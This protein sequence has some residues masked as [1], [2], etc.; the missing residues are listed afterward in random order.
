MSEEVK[1]KYIKGMP[2]GGIADNGDVVL[3][4]LVYKDGSA[5][6]FAFDSE[7]GQMLLGNLRGY[8]EEAAKTRASGTSKVAEG[9]APYRVTN[10]L[11]AGPSVDGT[12]V[13][14]EFATASGFPLALAMTNDQAKQTV[15]L[16]QRSIQAAQ[17]SKDSLN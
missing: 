2:W 15:E 3:F 7:V 17:K 10:I 4:Q 16:L 5:E 9:T 14:V 1:A 11:R 8:A 13:S 6:K 12:M